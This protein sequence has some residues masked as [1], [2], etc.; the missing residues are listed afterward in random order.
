MIKAILFDIDNTLIDFMGM[1]KKSSEA[2]IEAMIKAGLNMSKSDALKLMYE[3]YELHGI[4]SQR[5]FQKFTKKIYGKENYKLISYGV[6]AYRKMRETYLAPYTNVIP[7]LIE[8]KRLGYKLAIVS[9]APIMEAWMRIASLN[10]DEFFE[11]IITKADARRQKTH[12]APFKLAL[13]RLNI[14]P[15]EAVMVGDRIERDVNTAKKLGIKTIYARYGDE[16]P[17]ERG[18]SGADFEINDISEILK[19]LK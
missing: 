16:N 18:K 2:A 8:V 4:E 14:K 17:P 19:V 1:K 12:T 5:I 13:R 9:D 15:E 11:V 6:L 3:L 7:T 10:L